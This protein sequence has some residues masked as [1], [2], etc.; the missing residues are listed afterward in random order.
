MQNIKCLW[1]ELE[2]VAAPPRMRHRAVQVI[3][4]S[5]R[6]RLNAVYDVTD[7]SNDGSGMNCEKNCSCYHWYTKSL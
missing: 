7:S 6:D 4:S 5:G 3:R 2:T 1:I